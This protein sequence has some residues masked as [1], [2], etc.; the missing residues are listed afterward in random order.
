MSDTLRAGS[1]PAIFSA[2][3]AFVH[4]LR[5]EDLPAA[6]VRRADLVVMDLIGSTWAVLGADGSR[7]LWRYARAMNP[8]P[9][10]TLWGTPHKVAVAEAAT[11]NGALGYEAEFDDGNTLGGH[12]GSSSI[13]TILALAQRQGASAAEVVLAIVAAYEVGNRVS[14]LVSRGLLERG[15]HFPGTMGAIAAIAGAGRL[16]GLSPEALAGALGHAALLPVA[17]YFPGHVGADTKNLYSGWPNHCGVHFTA[18]AQAG[19]LGAPDLLEGRDGLAR[20]LGWQGQPGQLAASALD[21]L[22]RD[23]AITQTYFKAYPCCRWLQAPVQS[24]L[25]LMAANGLDPLDVADIR[26]MGPAFL[27][28]YATGER[29]VNPIQG[30]YSLAHCVGAAAARRALGQAEFSVAALEDPLIAEMSQRVEFAVDARLE[31]QFP[32]RYATVVELATRDGRRLRAEDVPPWGPDQPPDLDA[33]AG[34]FMPIMRRACGDAV[35]GDW[36]AWFRRGF[37]ADSQLT[38]FFSLLQRSVVR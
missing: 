11:V 26:V 30:K 24:V 21:G 36:L 19:Y 9:E 13:P 4:G 18:L 12:W 34:K 5:I 31:A 3:A 8:S 38:A 17:P 10:A 1:A 7:A 2:L 33:L 15:I 6:A 35:A 37:L 29:C 16:M 28:M 14:R 23:W 32:G 22:G 25:D 20:A 27:A